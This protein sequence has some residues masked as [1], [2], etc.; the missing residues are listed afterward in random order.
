M[1]YLTR[2]YFPLQHISPLLGCSTPPM[3]CFSLSHFLGI[4]VALTLM[5]LLH[6]L[7]HPY[8]VLM[9]RHRCMIRHLQCLRVPLLEL[10]RVWRPSASHPHLLLDRHDLCRLL[11]LHQAL[12]NDRHRHETC[13][14]LPLHRVLCAMLHARPV[15]TLQLRPRLQQLGCFKTRLRPQLQQLHHFQMHLR[16]PLQQLYRFQIRLRSTVTI[17][18]ASLDD[19]A[20][21]HQAPDTVS[22]PRPTQ[23]V[24][25]STCAAPAP[26]VRHVSPTADQMV[27]PHRTRLQGS[28]RKPKE[29]T[30]GTVRYDNVAIS[31]NLL[32]CMRLLLF[33]TGRW[34]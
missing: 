1:C 32:I 4:I 29:F 3:S 8:L 18:A 20:V 21:L 28:I 14:V 31:V 12:Y 23:D 13:R 16:P 26:A 11:H 33:L 2:N 25:P 9:C 5:Y 22:V 19:A 10:Q 34:R 15:W 27:L 30:D 7:F 17:L 24:A 6:V